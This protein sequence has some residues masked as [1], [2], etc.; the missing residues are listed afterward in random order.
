MLHYII[1]QPMSK[2]VVAAECISVKFVFLCIVI[3]GAMEI[4]YNLHVN[5]HS[6]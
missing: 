2:V 6:S 4:K 5:F 3:D 1:R